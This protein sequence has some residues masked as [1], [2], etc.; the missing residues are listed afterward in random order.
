MPKITHLKEFEGGLWARLEIDHATSEGAVHVY[1]DAEVAKMKSDV[2]RDVWQT[3]KDA[4][5]SSNDTWE[6]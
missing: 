5:D 1:T 6:D 4:C 3:I 2:R